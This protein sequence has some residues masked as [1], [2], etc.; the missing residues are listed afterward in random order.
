VA[1]Q[2]TALAQ[3]ELEKFFAAN[4]AIEPFEVPARHRDGH[5]MVV[6]IRSFPITDSRGNVTGF[7]GVARDVTEQK[8]AELALRRAN[9]Q[10]TLLG[11]VSRHDSLNKITVIHGFLKIASLKCTDPVVSDLLK[12]M[13]S[14]TVAMRSQIEFTRFY[15]DLGSREPQ[16]IPLD[17][18]LSGLQVPEGI[19]LVTEIRGVRLFADAMLEKVFTNLLDNTIRHG[20][21]VSEIRVTSRTEGTTLVVVWEDNGAGV[22]AAV[23]ERIFDRGYGKNTGLG[24]FLSREIL[25]LTGITIRETGVSG[26]GARFEL[27]VPEGAYRLDGAA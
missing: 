23:K 14:A 12:K 15:Q 9:R 1:E 11:S 19:S 16:W 17:T 22:P 10:L 24:L 13:E 27:V 5:D 21:H 4:R 6:E 25:A 7:R 18:V 20:E 26:I 3:R 8:K 2:G